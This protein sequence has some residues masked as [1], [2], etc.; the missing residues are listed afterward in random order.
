MADSKIN[1]ENVA[2]K[3]MGFYLY[4]RIEPLRSAVRWSAEQTYLYHGPS[5]FSVPFACSRRQAGDGWCARNG[6]RPGA[7]TLAASTA[8]CWPFGHPL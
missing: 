6:L 1:I 5:G 7:T 4:N 2:G 8:A 3:S